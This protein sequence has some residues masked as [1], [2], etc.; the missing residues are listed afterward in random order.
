VSGPESCAEAA[1]LELCAN[2]GYCG[3]SQ[4]AVE[5]LATTADDPDAWVDAVLAAEGIEPPLA[6]KE[7]RRQVRKVICDWVFDE[8]RG[9]GT[10]SGLPRFPSGA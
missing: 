1:L 2:Y 8:G 7:A 4:K 3:A 5:F 9:R 10:K 6:D